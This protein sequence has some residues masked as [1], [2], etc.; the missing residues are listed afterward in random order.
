MHRTSDNPICKSC[1]FKLCDE[2]YYKICEKYK[3]EYGVLYGNKT[4]EQAEAQDNRWKTADRIIKIILITILIIV[5][6]VVLYF[7]ASS[8]MAALLF[9]AIILFIKASR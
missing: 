1:K 7:V 3:N 4:T 8:T 2:N 6:G 5:A 9:L